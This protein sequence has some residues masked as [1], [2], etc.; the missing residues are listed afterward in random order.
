MPPP[1]DA[2]AMP[3][4]SEPPRA[5]TPWIAV[6]L[7]LPVLAALIRHFDFICDDAFISFRYAR[8]LAEGHGLRFNLTEAR[9]IEGYTN[10]LWVLIMAGV[11]RLRGDPTVWSRIL[12]IASSVTLLAWT[13]RAA[14]RLFPLNAAG[15]FAT[16]LCFATLPTIAVYSTSGLAAMP[17]ALCVFGLW[18]R[19]LADPERPRALQASL[20]GAALVLLRA[21]GFL[22]AGVV[23]GLALTEA[24]V[25]RRGSLARAALIAGLACG[26]VFG[27]HVAWRLSYYGDWLPN[28]ARVKVMAASEAGAKAMRRERGAKYLA[29]YLLEVLS[30]AI[31]PIA[32]GLATLLSPSCAPRRACVHALAMTLAFYGYGV[33]VGGD[34]MTFG[35]FFLPAM[36]FLA[37]LF[38][39]TISALG[40]LAGARRFSAHAFTLLVVTLS[41]LPSWDVQAVPKGWLDAV[42]F[43]WNDP[44]AKRQT[45]RTRWLDMDQNARRWTHQGKALAQIAKP[46]ES[47]IAGGMG[48]LGY[49]SDLEIF[50]LYCLTNHEWRTFQ[51]DARRKS[52]GHDLSLQPEHFFAQHPTY[53]GVIDTFRSVDWPPRLGSVESWQSHPWSKF[54]RVE[55][56]PYPPE[57][58]AKRDLW[59]LRFERWE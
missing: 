41:L 11:E 21:D 20:F 58:A 51:G 25:L 4:G 42:H 35:R 59:V 31:V 3:P 23:V 39:A 17:V 48:A 50:D 38:A 7:A 24:L 9:P 52:P 54:V 14:S 55:R 45:E 56:H 6:A 18:E 34:F 10:F 19:L 12:T 44:V 8:H 32:G 36:P 29:S 22:F 16:A 57:V 53:L 37:L 1:A 40:G 33:A 26:V 13:T 28:T 27:A 30:T 5:R 43:R 46:G 47:M 2:V 49:Y 15:S